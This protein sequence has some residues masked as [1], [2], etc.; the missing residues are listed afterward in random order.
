MDL[1]HY[2]QK[3]MEAKETERKAIEARR[4]AEDRLLSLIGIPNNKEG[5]TNVNT[6]DGYKIKVV[7]RFNQ[8]IDSDKLQ[9]IATDSGLSEHLHSLFRW[10]PE[11]VAKEWKASHRDITSVLEGAI[12]TEP[13][14]PSFTI[15]L[16]E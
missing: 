7:S 16:G 8:K 3:W 5:T 11:I 1:A 14:R 13:A 4:E 15:T 6:D 2:A 10:K 12:T 9:E